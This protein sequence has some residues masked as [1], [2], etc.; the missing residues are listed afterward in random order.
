MS[1]GIVQRIFLDHF[2]SY[3]ATHKVSR[4]EWKAAGSILSC[5][6]HKLGY[7]IDECPNGHHRVVLKNSCKHRSC[8]QCGSTETEVWLARR[9]LQALDCS[10]HHII[11]T[12]HHDLHVIWMWNRKLFT[13]LLFPAAWHCLRELLGSEH[14]LGVY[15]GAIGVFQS[16]GDELQ[17][18]CHLHFIVPAGGLDKNGKWKGFDGDFLIPTPVLAAKFRGK[19]LA[20]LNDGFKTVT[21][22]GIQKPKS[23]V[24]RAPSGMSVRQCLNLFNKLGRVRWHA[25]IE[26][27]YEH[28]NGVFKYVGRYIRRGPIS[29]KRIVKYD[30]KKVHIVYAHPEKH[31]K[32]VFRLGAEEF[33]KRLLIH[34]PEKNT[35]MVR[36]YGLFHPNC[37]KKLNMAR[38][39]LGQ[40][41][42][43]PMTELP[44]AQE[45]LNRMFPD[46]D[47]IRCP[48][49]GAL[50]R[51]VHYHH[52]GQPP[53]ERMAA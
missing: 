47:A 23:H 41:S 20:Y 21:K 50:L 7:H 17:K 35:H 8:P 34:V 24:L 11:I 19:F 39:Q 32:R 36:S 27:A 4:R 1:K 18:H 42:Y 33:I 37:I 53:P 46:W 12:I 52:R 45:L 26:P 15:T 5:R 49:C 6:T 44:H 2:K 48:E 25:D 28:A 40:P 16:W 14:W 9:K 31:E 43:K 38:A 51:T 30:G 22:R 10:Y 13:N 29:E 3:L